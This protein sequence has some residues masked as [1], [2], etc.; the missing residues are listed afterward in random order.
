MKCKMQPFFFA[1][2]FMYVCIYYKHQKNI[3]RKNPTCDEEIITLVAIW[4]YR[5]GPW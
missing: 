5:R 4:W 3:V 2:N 1:H